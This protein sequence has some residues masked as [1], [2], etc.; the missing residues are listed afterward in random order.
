MLEN[1]KIAVVAGIIEGEGTFSLSKSTN[2]KNNKHYVSFNPQLII[3]NSNLR[4]LEFCQDILGGT[5]N[6]K[7]EPKGS[8][9]IHGRVFDLRITGQQQISDQINKLLPYLITKRKDAELLNEFCINRLHASQGPYSE[10]EKELHNI[11]CSLHAK[12]RALHRS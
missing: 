2:Q 6:E 4:L 1:E 3:I 11:L 9:P 12:G 7:E 10:R 8:Y 5:I